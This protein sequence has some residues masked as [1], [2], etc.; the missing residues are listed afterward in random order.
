M[1]KLK[2]NINQFHNP[3]LFT[4]PRIP[5]KKI[6]VAVRCIGIGIIL[7]RDIFLR[8][9]S[10]ITLFNQN[11]ILMK[12]QTNSL[13]SQSRNKASKRLICPTKL[14]MMVRITE[15]TFQLKLINL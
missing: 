6:S 7:L 8:V 3:S 2:D 1:K 5:L 11:T 13:A 14:S 12:A 10:K 15:F 9:D 4:M